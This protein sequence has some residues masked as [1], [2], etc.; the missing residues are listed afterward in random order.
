[1]R[2]KGDSTKPT[3]PEAI[4][5]EHLE[6]IE[7]AIR[8]ALR[9]GPRACEDPDDF[10][11]WVK[12]KLIEND[13]AII[14]KFEH[15]STFA[16]FISVVVHRL[17]AD[18]RIAHWGK[19]HPSSQAKH[20][21]EPA[22]TIEILLIRDGRSLDEALALLKT[23]W[24]YLT[25]EEVTQIAAR[26]PQRPRRPRPVDID[27]AS[28]LAGGP[29]PDD[30][31][32]DSE[33]RRIAERL[34]DIIRK[35][36]ADLDTHDRLILRLHFEGGVSVAEISRTLHLEH[37][38]LYRRLQRAL[39]ILRTRVQAA[40]IGSDEVEDILTTRRPELDF[41]LD[42]ERS[43]DGASTARGSICDDEQ[44]GR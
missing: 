22:L 43:G 11:S 16:A 24:P 41:A 25:A 38:P 3:G 20:L 15:R 17:F 34:G 32:I 44:T 9:G 2:S 33:R 14:R 30:I 8:F 10:A 5:L 42:T 29:R 27:D 6:T 28:G 23:R 21:G 4:F 26:L 40:G 18:Y 31:A 12:L 36:L 7:K 39:A 35:A 37:K 19:W 1:V 13:Y